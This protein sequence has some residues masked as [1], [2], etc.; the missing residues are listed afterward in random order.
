MNLFYAAATSIP[1]VPRRPKEYVHD[2]FR[3]DKLEM[4]ATRFSAEEVGRRGQELYEQQIRAQVETLENI[5][6]IVVID[7]ETG[8]FEISQDGLTANKRALANHPEG[9]FYGVRVGYEAV[10]SLSGG[11]LRRVKTLFG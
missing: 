4:P 6:K 5:G 9:T 11:G 1:E 7:I 2:P 8:A 10:E 3:K